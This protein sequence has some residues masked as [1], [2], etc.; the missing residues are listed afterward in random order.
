MSSQSP[1]I[2]Y[3]VAKSAMEFKLA[4]R[5]FREY[6]ATLQ[7]NLSFQ[8]FE[9][10]IKHLKTQYSNP[11]GVL[12]LALDRENAIGCAGVRALKPGIAELKRM[13]VRPVYRRLGIG[14]KLLRLS[15]EEAKI[16]H[17]DKIRLDTLIGMG[18]ARQLYRAF[19]FYEIAP[20]YHNP[21]KETIFMEK[22]LR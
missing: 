6:E 8:D 21:I 11:K 4:E 22:K 20:Y 2:T 13:F 12:L 16:L 9:E 18:E 3:E 7:I 10:E 19:G 15:I 14:K 1:H 5:L 17:Y